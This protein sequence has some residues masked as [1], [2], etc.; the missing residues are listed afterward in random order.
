MAKI[1]SATIRLTLR[2]NKTLAN[3][4]H[5]IMLTVQFNGK[6]EKSTGYACREIDWDR[7]NERIKNKAF[8]N[9]INI[10]KAISDFKHKIEKKKLDFEIKG[11]QYTAAML[12]DDENRD[13]SANGLVFNE[14][15]DNYLNRHTHS[16]HTKRSYMFMKYCLSQYVGHKDFLIYDI[17]EEFCIRFGKWLQTELVCKDGKI[18]IAEGSIRTVFSKIAAI[19]NHCIDHNIIKAD[20]Y[21]FRRFKY[22]NVYKKSNKKQAISTNN[23]LAIH[24]YFYDLVYSNIEAQTC[25]EMS[26]GKVY[27][28]ETVIER[29][30]KRYTI[31]HSCA[32]FLFGWLAQGLAMTDIAD[33]KKEDIIIKKT[34]QNGT[35]QKVYIINTDRNKTNKSVPIAILQDDFSQS[36]IEPFLQTAHL[37]DN[38]L[39]PILQNNNH[40]YL[41]DTNTKKDV[42]KETTARATNKNLSTIAQEVNRRTKNFCAKNKMEIIPDEIPTDITFYAM[43]HSFA[44][45]FIQK[46]GN[47]VN[48]ATMMGRSPNGIFDY[49]KELTKF[50]DILKEKKNMY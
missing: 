12:L 4:M 10:N 46:G 16:Y 43:R 14:I 8:P 26:Y 40:E 30:Q 28:N 41:Y 33:L 37:R 25:I 7:Q 2:L 24:S 3:G 9:Y 23:I 5:P 6:K 42:A 11:Q 34:D 50:E 38:Y 29:L 13:F 17:T 35:Y 1:N 21:P 20:L 32:L 48:L 39:F 15:V 27:I 22:G 45:S 36:I 44:T 49:V 31:E 47:P 18:G 19:F